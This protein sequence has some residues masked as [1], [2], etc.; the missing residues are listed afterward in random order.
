MLDVRSGAEL[1]DLMEAH[2]TPVSS[3]VWADSQGSIGYKTVG[4]IPTRNGGS[5]DLPRCGWSGEDEWEDWIPY[6]EM[7]EVTDPETGYVVT[8]NNRIEPEGFEHHITSDYF[9]GFRATRIEQMIEA[10][11]VHDLDDV[12]PYADRHALPAR[13]RDGAPARAAATPRP[14][15][16]QRDRAPPQLG[17]ADGAGLDRRHASTRPSRCASP[18][19]SPAP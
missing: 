16:D 2:A 10:E 12:R 13:P 18:A 11:E 19:R 7:P 8:A 15:R 9:D 6:D 14:G 5:P 1:V 4:R 3:L 17:R